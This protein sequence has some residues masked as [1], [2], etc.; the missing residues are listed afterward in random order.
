MEFDDLDRKLTAVFPG[1]VVRKDL[2]HQIKGGENV[3]SYVLEYLLGKYCASDDAEE[4]RIGIEA[5]KETLATNYFRHDEA[6]KAQS[7]GRAEGPPP[8]HRPHRGAVLPRQREQVLGRDGQLQLLADPRSPRSSTAATTVSSRAGSGRIVDVEFRADEETGQGTSPFHIADLRPIQL[9]HFDFRRVHRWR[10]LNSARRNG[11]TPWCGAS[12]YASERLEHAAE[13]TAPAVALIPLVEKNYNF[14]ELGPRGTG[15]SYAFS[16]M[17]PYCILISGGKATPANLFYNNARRQ[18]RPRRVLG[19]GRLRRGRRH[20]GHRPRRHPDHEGLHGERALQPRRHA[21]PRGCLARL[22][23]QPQPAGR[24]A[25]RRMPRPT[26]SSRYPRSSTSRSWIGS[27]S[28]CRG[29]R[30]PRTRSDILTTR[31]GFVTDYLAEAFRHAPK[32]E[33]VRRSRAALPLRSARRGPRRYRDPKDGQRALKLLHPDGGYTKEELRDVC[34]AR[35]RAAPPGQGAAEEARFVRVLQDELLVHR[36]R[37]R[38]G[39]DSRRP[40]AG[41]AG[42]DLPGSAIARI[43]LHRGCGRRGQGRACSV[44]RSASRAGTGKVR[45]PAGM[46]E[47]LKESLNRADELPQLRQGSSGLDPNAG[48]AATSRRGRRSLRWKGVRRVRRRLLCRHHFGAPGE[49]VVQAGTVILGDL[50]IQ[51]NLKGLASITEPLQVCLRERRAPR[52]RSD[53]E[54]VAV[55]RR[56]QKRSSRSSTS[57]A[58]A[59]LTARWSRRWTSAKQ[60]SEPLA[61]ALLVNTEPDEK[62]MTW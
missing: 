16:E 48:P 15:K 9:A 28:I 40:R 7:D 36:H 30:S 10:G 32:A 51:G 23:R 59:M 45:T 25:G 47:G 5:V 22:R 24:D 20:E 13:A 1:K 38:R 58:M 43:R 50:T 61:V 21:G 19:C 14:I 26:S 55:R 39:A 12:D 46:D 54:Q 56:C 52:A 8:V 44:W 17:S 37:S 42:G 31:Y 53:L 62:E 29:G 35:R 41:R 18:G 2:L 33:P 4:V 27:T 34:R 49:A 57:S 60:S 3:P 6:N 11:P